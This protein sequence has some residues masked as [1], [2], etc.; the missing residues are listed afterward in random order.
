MSPAPQTRIVGTPQIRKEGMDKV[1]GHARSFDDIRSRVMYRS[2]V[3][4]NLLDEFLD[5]LEQAAELIA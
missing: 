5:T 1:L 4:A 3:A 2:H